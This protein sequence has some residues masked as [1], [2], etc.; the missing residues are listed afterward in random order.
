MMLLRNIYR[1]VDSVDCVNTVDY[2]NMLT[3]QHD[4]SDHV[5]MST[6]LTKS[7][8]ELRSDL[9]RGPS[10]PSGEYYW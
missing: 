7:T 8:S 5:D 3:S 6:L 9:G 4:H 2:V 1:Q 10:V